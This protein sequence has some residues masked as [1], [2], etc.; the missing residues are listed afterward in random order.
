[1]TQSHNRT[2]SSSKDRRT[3][4]APPA[5]AEEEVKQIK[6]ENQHEKIRREVKAAEKKIASGVQTLYALAQTKNPQYDAQGVAIVEINPED[7]SDDIKKQFPNKLEN[8]ITIHLF[9]KDFIRHPELFYMLQQKVRSLCIAAMRSGLI[10]ETNANVI[11]IKLKEKIRLLSTKFIYENDFDF[12]EKSKT[13]MNEIVKETFAELCKSHQAISSS[14]LPI[15]TFV[16]AVTEASLHTLSTSA[17]ILTF[18]EEHN[19]GSYAEGAEICAH[20]RDLDT[21]CANL[22]WAVNFNYKP[23]AD[24][25]KLEAVTITSS[26]LK[27]AS[28]APIDAIKAKED[29][30]DILISTYDHME[31]VIRR[32]ASLCLHGRDSKEA[33]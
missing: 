33:K 25:K 26:I 2:G 12:H 3:S 9:K 16:Q 13:L 29:P 31:E 30:A 22:G 8:G 18:N 7:I 19:Q 11:N 4:S 6:Q 20:E 1:M 24:P 21:P 27:H 5:S 14:P 23:S 17:D 10:S 15:E 32:L 28:L